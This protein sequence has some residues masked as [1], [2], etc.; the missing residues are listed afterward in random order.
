MKTLANLLWFFLAGLWTAIG[1]VIA[2]ALCIVLI[3]T[4]PLAVPAFRMA[5][6]VIWPFGRTV[7]KDPARGRLLSGGANLV[8]IVFFGW[9]LALAHLLTG[10]LLCLTVIGIPLGLAQMKMAP[11]AF[12]PYGK[13]IVPVDVARVQH[14]QPVAEISS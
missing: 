9:W 11:L 13:M 4:I 1:Y 3:V 5:T 8:W 12:A 7:V 2:G 6:Y 14:L 10:A